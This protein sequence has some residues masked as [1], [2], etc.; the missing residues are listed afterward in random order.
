MEGAWAQFAKN[1]TLGPGWNQLG[2]F[3]GSDLGAL[4]SGGSSGVTLISQTE[5]DARCDLFKP[6][7]NQI[8]TPAF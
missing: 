5:V 8:L 4:G 1:P 7:Y 3:N 6:I 2:T